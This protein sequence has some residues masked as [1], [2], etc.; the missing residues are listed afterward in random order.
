MDSTLV[1]KNSHTYCK[2]LQ[3]IK[4]QALRACSQ[5]D[6]LVG[7]DHRSSPTATHKEDNQRNTSCFKFVTQRLP[8]VHA[9]GLANSNTSISQIHNYPTSMTLISTPVYLKTIIKHQID[10]SIQ[11]TSYDSFYYTQLGCPSFQEQFYNHRKYHAVLKYSQNNIS[12][13]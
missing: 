12:E 11:F 3:V 7:K 8:Y 10:H 2:N 4:N 13:A 5:G 9:T 6:R 1:I